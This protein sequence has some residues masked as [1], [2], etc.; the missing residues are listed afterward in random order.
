MRLLSG[1]SAPAACRV[2]IGGAGTEV[3]FPSN[4][5][6]PK[7][8]IVPAHWLGRLMFLSHGSLRAALNAVRQS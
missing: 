8:C 3:G 6:A 7:A 1:I 2:I 4:D 5:L